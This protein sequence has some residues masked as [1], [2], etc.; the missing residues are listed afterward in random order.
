MYVSERRIA[1]EGASNIT[2]QNSLTGLGGVLGR[3]VGGEMGSEAAGLAWT[4][5]THV[6]HM[7]YVCI[8]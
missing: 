1:A 3:W 2:S 5:L 8:C 4:G 7:L 6:V